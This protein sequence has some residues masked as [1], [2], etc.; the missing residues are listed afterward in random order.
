[1]QMWACVMLGTWDHHTSSLSPLVLLSLSRSPEPCTA[2][3]S[4]LCPLGGC[5]L[6]GGDCSGSPLL[7]APWT[8]KHHRRQHL[9]PA[10]LSCSQTIH[11]PAMLITQNVAA[12]VSIGLKSGSQ[13]QEAISCCLAVPNTSSKLLHTP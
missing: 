12:L 9:L 10:G 1:M 8:C 11:L 2:V 3:L 6:G 13:Q 5:V 7:I 4:L